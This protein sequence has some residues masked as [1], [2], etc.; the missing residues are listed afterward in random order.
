MSTQTQ[1][2]QAR[3]T[4]SFQAEISQ[5]LDI[6]INSLYTDDEIFIRELISNANDALEKVRHELLVDKE[7]PGQ[8]IPL[9]IRIKLDKEAKTFTIEDTGIGMSREELL[10]NLG[11]IARSGTKEFVKNAIAAAKEPSANLIGQF[12]VGF[13]SAFMVANKVVVETRGLR[14]DA[15]GWLWESDGSGAFTIEAKEGLERGTRITVHLKEEK[16]DYAEDFH[17]RQIIR[18][19]SSF[20]PFPIMLD[21]EKTNTVQALWSRSKAEIKDEEYTEFYRFIA[22][23]TDDPLY[24]QHFSADVPLAINALIF[25]PGDTVERMGFGRTE[26]GVDLYCRRVMIQKHPEKLLPEWLR[27]VRGVI[28]SDDLPLNIS[29]ETMQDSA[30]VRKLSRVITKRFLKFLAEEAG[31]D[32]EKYKD[33]FEKFGRFIKEGITT[34]FTH[35]DDLAKLLRFESSTTEPGKLT[36][37]DEY[38]SRMPEGQEAIYYISGPTR[39]AIE[40]G[41]YIEALR[42]RGFEVIYNFDQV[43]DFV[44]DHLGRYQEKELKSAD[45]GD[46]DLPE[47]E[48]KEDQ[49]ELSSE[50]ATELCGWIKEH[51]GAR[52]GSVRPS[53]RLVTNP[54]VAVTEGGMTAG[55]QRILSA[56]NKDS[57]PMGGASMTLEINPRSPLIHKI[58]NLKGENGEFAGLLTDQLYDNALLAA[59]VLADPRAMADRLNQLLNKAAGV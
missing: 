10:N 24:C 5:L 57:S 11:T 35:R 50:E 42:E 25:V 48:K 39:E 52:I 46:L 8:D 44:Y 27:F 20:V 28:D 53:K 15:S 38:I 59:G 31:K 29:R 37:L 51:L 6:V 19:F 56:I 12:G 55:M 7:L 23:A 4:H 30:L 47:I 3:E 17:V 43:D 26:P 33:F 2:Q 14:D 36:S 45:R 18:K 34:D 49:V 58:H 1:D 41:P 54:A 22:N 16:A 13:Y 21:G 40:A 32:E 9:E